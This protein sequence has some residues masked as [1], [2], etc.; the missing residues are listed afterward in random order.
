MAIVKPFKGVR[1]SRDKANLVVSRS[2]HIYTE[3][4]LEARLDY[5]PYSFLHI[6]NP[7]YKYQKEI[8]GELRFK[9]VKNRYDEFKDERFFIKDEKPAYYL[10]KKVT[11]EH[12]FCGII[13][14][15]SVED[16]K[17]N[18]IKKHEET[19]AYKEE[20]F[21]E[22]LKTVGFNAEP[23][24]LT[25]PDNDVLATLY[26]EIMS[27]RP[28]Y[29]F[30]TTDKV[31]HYLW[32]I[33]KPENI[34]IIQEQFQAMEALYI[35]DGHHRSASSA[36]LADDLKSTNEHHTGEEDYNFCMSYLI[37]ES[38]LKIYEF[39]RLIKDLNGHSKDDLLLRLDEFFRIENRGVQQYKPSKKHHFSMYLDGEFYSLYLR[40]SLYNFSNSLEELD[41]QILYDLVLNP[42]L[43]INDLRNDSRI[44][45]FPGTK[46][47]IALKEKMDTQGFEL[48]FGMVPI[49]IEEMKNIA[50]EGLK[51]P[52]KSTYIEPKLRSGLTIYEF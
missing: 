50:D 37:P 16:Y 41:A 14:A 52:P 10:Y 21:K 8:S 46:D 20:L 17:N 19:I 44:D 33:D 29:E 12:T 34:K 48:A 45:Y 32:Y 25:Y 22:Y 2:Y 28:E 35:A 11:R 24:L 47:A 39:Y 40:K 36:L 43:G 9:L 26:K 5:N 42:I 38:N 51:M 13:G 3:K 15:S 1:P 49:T 4:E 30:S 6:I 7:G 27:I 18:V 23:V 31:S